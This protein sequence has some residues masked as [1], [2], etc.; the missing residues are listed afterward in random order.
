MK[1][2]PQS[3]NAVDDLENPSSEDDAMLGVRGSLK[4]RKSFSRFRT[5]VSLCV[6]FSF[7]VG[8]GL[9][10]RYLLYSPSDNQCVELTTQATPLLED[11]MISYGK[12]TY[13]GSFMTENIYRQSAAPEV[14]EA[15]EALGVNY[16]SV[17]IPS[18]RAKEA[19]L[20][21]DHVQINPK[22]GGGFPAN[23]EGLHHLHCL[24]LVRQSLYYNFDYYKAK[25][26]GAFKNDDDILKLHVSHCL[27]ILRQQLMCTIDVGVFGQVW[28]TPSPGSVPA[29]FVDFNTQH[30]CR[31][32]DDIRRWA[33][34]RQLPKDV[35]EDFLQPPYSDSIILDGVP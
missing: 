34:V 3:L 13:N 12:L 29:A 22:Y 11:I 31:N 24:N 15:W 14:D 16:R 18:E 19:G 35:P 10:S 1:A 6:A 28:Y 4:G 8:M 20:R 27:D 25:K 33:E 30:K 21:K 7:G 5:Y 23:V 26:Q 9:L 17:R 32:F 2:S